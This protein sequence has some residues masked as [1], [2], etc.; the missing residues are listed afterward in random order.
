M[1][2][3]L[4]FWLLT[5][6]VCHCQR[7]KIRNRFPIACKLKKKYSSADDQPLLHTQGNGYVAY[8]IFHPGYYNQQ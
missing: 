4:L 2:Y 5:F 1:F 8:R 6:S 7:I 3:F